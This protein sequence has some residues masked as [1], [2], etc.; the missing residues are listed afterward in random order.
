[1]LALAALVLGIGVTTTGVG[2][3]G[4]EREGSL[5]IDQA[6]TQTSTTPRLPPL[7]LRAP[8]EFQTASFAF[9]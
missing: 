4:D 3:S 5:S 1:V 2:C 7:D 6:G 9:G 8:A